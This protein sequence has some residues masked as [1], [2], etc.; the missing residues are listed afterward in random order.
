MFTIRLMAPVAGRTYDVL[1]ALSLAEILLLLDQPL[2]M[3]NSGFL[4]SF[5]AVIGMTVIRP[6]LSLEPFMKN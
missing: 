5:G 4:F 6:A 3:Y 1:T 2:Y